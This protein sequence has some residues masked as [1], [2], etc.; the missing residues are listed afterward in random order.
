MVSNSGHH[1][2]VQ[3]RLF[4]K[5]SEDLANQIA[6]TTVSAYLVVIQVTDSNILSASINMDYIM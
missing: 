1:A 2:Q 6:I 4:I 5:Y 3:C